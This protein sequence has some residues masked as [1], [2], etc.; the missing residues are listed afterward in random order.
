MISVGW[1][2]GPA[3]EE[4]SS[5]GFIVN[6]AGRG[7]GTEGLRIL[8]E[9]VA[10]IPAIDAILRDTA[11]FKIGPFALM[12]LTGLDVSHPVM[13]SIYRQYYEEPRFRPQPLTRQML[14]AGTLG[15]K[16]G[17]GFYAYPGGTQEIPP[18][19]PA[20]PEPTKVKSLRKRA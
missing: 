8:S 2:K 7:F 18:E 16:T 12:D 3:K 19:A 4:S 15:R 17:R 20:P 14:A 9:G 10:G 13:E 5:P 11:G 6:H 1:P